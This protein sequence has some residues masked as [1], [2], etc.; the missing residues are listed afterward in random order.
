MGVTIEVG[1]LS[2]PAIK[3]LGFHRQH[4]S[5]DLARKLGITVV[6]EYDI[7]SSIDS[8]K[9]PNGE[10]LVKNGYKAS[11]KVAELIHEM[12]IF[13]KDPGGLSSMKKIWNQRKKY[14]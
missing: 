5:N 9:Q 8:M 11:L 6:S 2:I 14:R 10:R 12:K 13:T 3:L 1:A 4:A 7:A